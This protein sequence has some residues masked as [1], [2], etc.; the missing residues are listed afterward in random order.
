VNV[1]L[2]YGISGRSASEVA[3]SVERGILEGR[4]P[5][6]A[7]LPT[8]RALAAALRLSAATVA[9]AYRTLRVRGLV[10]GEGRRGTRVVLRPPLVVRR[11]PVAPSGARDLA[12]GNPDPALLPDLRP[13]LRRLCGRPGLYG[14]VDPLPELR[15]LAARHLSADG[16]P[17]GALA[18]VG[19]AMDGIE[20]VLQAHLRPGDRV[21][22]EDP[23]YAGVLDLLGAMGLVAEPVAIDDFGVRPDALAAA[24]SPE[25][26]AVVLTPR[27][28]NPTGAAFDEARARALRAILDRHP[29]VLVI[30]DD[31]AG[32][33]A[34]APAYTVVH[35]RK[36]RWAI[37]RSVC[38]S[39]GP[40]LRLAVLAG[41][42]TTVARVEGRRSLGTG[43]VSH[44]LQAVVASL[45]SDAA[46][47]RRLRE[48]ADV[49]TRRRRA[50]VDALARH[51]IAAH[52]RSGLNVWVPV[53]EEAATIAAMAA[54]G[55]AI[56][57]G[58]PYRLQSPPAVRITTSTLAVED[59]PKVASALAQVLDPARV[60]TPA[61]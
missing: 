48:A 16:I 53:R 54:A 37:V 42:A 44:L 12:E 28:Q 43:W 27:A 21:V 61:A 38:K 32:P 20:R 33:V 50:L 23:G 18:I 39:L 58:E 24:L 15:G 3:T 34:G 22:V 5:P 29:D 60:R 25:T 11:P 6:G 56:R 59:A 51:G 47:E 55:W 46:I 2:Q 49:Y 10:A 26:G 40:D 8:V 45:W 30:E 19:G 36:R 35:A 41:D 57:A 1:P 9:A 14:A 13:A 4:I 7:P 31:H 52:A 17:A